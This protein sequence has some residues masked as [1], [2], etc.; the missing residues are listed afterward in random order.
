[1]RAARCRLLRCAVL[2]GVIV[3]AVLTSAGSA[4]M[5]AQAMQEIALWDNSGGTHLRGAVMTQR[6]SYAAI[7]GGALGPGPVGPP[8]TQT[9][10]AR[11]AARGAN[12]VVISH[13]GLF[14]EK[15]PFA[16]DQGVQQNLDNLLAMIAKADMFAVIA[17]R[18]GP[19]RSEFTFH[20]GE[21]GSWFGPEMYNDTVWADAK[22]QQA[23]VQM[24]RY[25][26]Q[27]YR[28]HPVVVGYELMVEPNSNAI[29]SNASKPLEIWDADTFYGKYAGSLL[30]WN[31]LHPKIVAG[32]RGVDPD[33]PVLIG[34][35]GYSGLDFLPYL[36]PSDDPRVVYVVHT[37]DPFQYTH[38]ETDGGLGYPG[39]YD[40]TWDDQ[41]DQFNAAFLDGVLSPIDDA[42]AAWGRPIAVTEYGTARWA[43]SSRRYLADMIQR[44]EAR[45]ANHTI[46]EWGS[47]YA[48]YV[49]V[50]N[51]F[52]LRC[53]ASAGNASEVK[54]S[55]VLSLLGT[56]WKRNQLR[57]SNVS[58]V[59]EGQ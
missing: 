34:G 53:G 59:H 21:A 27:R 26:A 18:T 58:L 48:P 43:P 5:A 14:G 42:R 4:A 55:P 10:F 39:D 17:F 13:P 40:V 9:D 22:A 38:Q 50:S 41:P 37:Y 56:V 45:G 15:P 51:M 19:G 52:N 23:W 33:T 32:V 57:P 49:E 25:T 20:L 44:F 29:G 7:D 35:N 36:E 16:L 47:A 12:L 1:M 6:R 54:T 3:L 8:Y 28:D 46:F 2:A 30:D 31:Q 24:W 11:L